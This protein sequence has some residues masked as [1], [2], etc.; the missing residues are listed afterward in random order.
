LEP[1]L[2][3]KIGHHRHLGFGSLRLRLLPESFTI[4]WAK[5]YVARG[6]PQEAW[7]LP[8]RVEDWLK[9]GVIAHYAELQKALDAKSL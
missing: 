4:D 7:R 6:A 8:L 1:G 5:R 3:H 9:P 2:A